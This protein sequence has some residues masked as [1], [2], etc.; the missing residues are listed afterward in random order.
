MTVYFTYYLY[1]IP[2]GK[3]YYGARWKPGC[4]PSDL[5]TTYF[6]SSKHVHKLIEEY[7]KDS[8]V[9][10]IRKT[11]EDK[12][13]CISWEQKVLK[14]LK[15]KTNSDWLNIAIG[16]P[17]MLGKSHSEETKQKMRKPKGP[18]TEERKRAKKEDELKKIAN[19]KI[20]PSTKGLTLQVK[21]ITCPHCN[22]SGALNNMK[23]YHLD[24]CKLSRH[25]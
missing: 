2:T 6:T 1:H 15:I 24:N 11:F 3:K 5:W 13:Q 22:K 8:F 20:M 25:A 7:G 10:Q 21:I 12:S 16:K 23:R 19:G 17:S 9:Y 14:R 18:W 4:Q